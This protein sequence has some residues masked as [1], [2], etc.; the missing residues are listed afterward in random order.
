MM[1]NKNQQNKIVKRWMHF[2]L[3]KTFRIYL[4]IVEFD[5]LLFINSITSRACL[6]RMLDFTIRIT[7]SLCLFLCT[8]IH[9]GYKIGNLK[10]NLI[11]WNFIRHSVRWNFHFQIMSP[12][13]IRHVLFYLSFKTYAIVISFWCTIKM[14]NNISFHLI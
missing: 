2:F 4:I 9:K 11:I 10:T 1:F 13:S 5:W 3:M 6:T 8:K 7:L 14:K 12:S